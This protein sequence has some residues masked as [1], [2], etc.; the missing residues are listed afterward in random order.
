MPIVYSRVSGVSGVSY[1]FADLDHKSTVRESR[2]S[3]ISPVAGHPIPA[4]SS[5]HHISDCVAKKPENLIKP[6]N[7]RLKFIQRLT[8]MAPKQPKSKKAIKE[9]R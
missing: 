5:S 8:S 9:Q 6:L 1:D 7:C 3:K 4:E 2:I